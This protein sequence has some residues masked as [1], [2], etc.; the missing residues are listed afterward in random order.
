MSHITSLGGKKEHDTRARQNGGENHTI[1]RE[2]RE[3]AA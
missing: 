2:K 1:G 3:N